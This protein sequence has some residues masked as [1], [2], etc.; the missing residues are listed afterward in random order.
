LSARDELDVITA[1]R[2]VGT[3]RG[4]AQMCGVDHKT[5]KRVVES[6]VVQGAVI[7]RRASAVSLLDR[8][9]HHNTVVATEGESYR[10]RQ[11]RD[12]TGGRPTT[13]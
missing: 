12:R 9:L 4:A 7:A 10:M 11:A 2:E 8:L 13:T 6:N 5:V 3:Y 1:Y